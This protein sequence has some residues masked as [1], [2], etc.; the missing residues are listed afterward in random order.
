MNNLFTLANDN[1]PEVEAIKEAVEEEN[2]DDHPSENC[3]FFKEDN[4]K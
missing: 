3:S 4:S 2:A 1:H